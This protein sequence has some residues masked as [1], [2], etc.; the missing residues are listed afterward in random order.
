MQMLAKEVGDLIKNAIKLSGKNQQEIA[1]Q[2]GITPA[3]LSEMLAGK[4]RLPL[5]RFHQIS[6][7]L[8]FDSETNKKINELYNAE[9][10]VLF[11]NWRQN[12]VEEYKRLFFDVDIFDNVNAINKALRDRDSLDKSSPNYYEDFDNENK[13]ITDE[14]M[15]MFQ[16]IAMTL[17]VDAL[18][19]DYNKLL[20][21]A[22]IQYERKILDAVMASSANPE[23]KIT[24]YNTIKDIK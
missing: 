24:I 20:V 1:I 11:T 18:P 16:K 15:N 6:K 9:Q 17:K 4:K 13:I 10:M 8:D 22:M 12:Q 23:A 21:D 2:I 3:A 14:L 5:K 7:I 19:V